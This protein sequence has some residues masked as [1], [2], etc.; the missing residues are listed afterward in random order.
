MINTIKVKAPAKINLT[1]DV[2]RRRNDG[3]HELKMIMQT[4]DICD[5]LT[6]TETGAADIE[7]TLEGFPEN[8]PKE[9]NLVYKAAKL[10]Q[11]TYS[12]PSGFSIH[13]KKEI[14]TAA[15]L[16]GGSS[17]C[18][19]TFLGIN[20]LFKLHLSK[21]E[22]CD[23]GV[24][25]GADVPF[26][27]YRGTMLAEGIGEILTP[28]PTLT[29]LWIV[30]LKPEISVSTGEVYEN[31]NLRYVYYHPNTK[32][33]IDAIAHRDYVS[34]GQNLANVL[35]TVTIDKHPILSDLKEFL[36]QSGALGAL[37]SG[38]GPTVFGFFKTLGLFFTVIIN[39]NWCVN[40]YAVK[41]L[42]I[43]PS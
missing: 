37:M 38:S 31:L 36:L 18:A 12:L 19:A 6:I 41:I 21:E 42:R 29:P 24:T 39:N 1:L 15:G 9:D 16:G 40:F 3:Y 35:E 13:L 17:D 7:L 43:I 32:M 22:L 26:C 10:M 25:L 34:L 30:L 33:A 8:L 5:E 14:P 20:E 4:I 27:I 11:E 2:K 28:L 23:L